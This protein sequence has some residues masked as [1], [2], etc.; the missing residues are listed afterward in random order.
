MKKIIFILAAAVAAAWP[1]TVV[2]PEEAS[3]KNRPAGEIIDISHEYAEGRLPLFDSPTGLGSF[4]V[5]FSSIKHGALANT[6]NFTLNSHSGT[7]VDAPGFLNHTLLQEGYDV[8]SLDLYTLTGPCMVVETPRDQNI[9]AE[10]MEG[11]NIAQGVERVLFKTLN[12]DR[13]LMYQPR[14]DSSYT[15]FTPDGARYLASHTDIKLVGI[16]YLSVGVREDLRDVYLTFLNTKV[17]TE[18]DGWF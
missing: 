18:I 17:R 8:D 14:F 4:Y 16:D 6:I 3:S 5:P 1:L 7:H 2:K 9:T 11:L 13:K 10:V 15:A 12:T